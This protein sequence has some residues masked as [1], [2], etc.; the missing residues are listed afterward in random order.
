M[1]T[2]WF[3][4]EDGPAARVDVS[5]KE[6][7]ID[8]WKREMI[9]QHPQMFGEDQETGVWHLYKSAEAEEPEES[10]TP[11]TDLVDAGK[12]GPTALVLKRAAGLSV[13]MI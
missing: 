13:G 7:I 5:N 10:W 9:R 11:V 1:K 6:L 12:T 3:K 4:V 2:L 8:D